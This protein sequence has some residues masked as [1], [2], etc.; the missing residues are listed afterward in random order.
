MKVTREML[1]NSY[2]DISL[3]INK[4]QKAFEPVWKKYRAEKIVSSTPPVFDVDFDADIKTALNSIAKEVNYNLT[5]D[6]RS[7]I[8]NASKMIDVDGD[9][10]YL[11]QTVKLAELYNGKLQNSLNIPK[12]SSIN[13]IKDLKKYS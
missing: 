4:V 12:R 13:D 2:N 8:L 5:V 9:F 1:I 6:N 3:F 7:L 11:K 10:K